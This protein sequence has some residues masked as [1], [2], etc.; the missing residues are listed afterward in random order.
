[1]SAWWIT[2]SSTEIVFRV[3]EE[4]NCPFYKAGDA[5]K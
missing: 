3:V 5:F 4:I 2:M 1:M